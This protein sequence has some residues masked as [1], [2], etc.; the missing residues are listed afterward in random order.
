MPL[1][2][3]LQYSLHGGSYTG[4]STV[5][6]SHVHSLFSRPNCGTAVN[7][8]RGVARSEEIHPQ[9]GDNGR[10][11]QARIGRTDGW[12]GRVAPS[13]PAMAPRPQRSQSAEGTE[14]SR[15]PGAGKIVEG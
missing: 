3:W 10:Q 14:G 8:D 6:P 1:L 12:V 11:R 15:G 13:L 7:V 9:G 2:L 5:S 4:G